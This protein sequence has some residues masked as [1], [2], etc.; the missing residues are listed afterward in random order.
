MLKNMN[1][2]PARMPQRFETTLRQGT[3]IKAAR[4]REGGAGSSTYRNRRHQRSELAGEADCDQVNDVAER[5]KTAQFRRALHGKDE[6]SA[7]GHQRNHRNRIDTDLQHLPY[8]SF[9][10]ITVSDKGKRLRHCPHCGPPLNVQTS[11]IVEVFDCSFANVFENVCHQ[12]APFPPELLSNSASNPADSNNWNTEPC[13]C[14]W[15]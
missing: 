12:D 6:S 5:S 9:P 15:N 7:N 10:A 3:E 11:D 8:S 2:P 1:N 13:P 4:Y 14:K